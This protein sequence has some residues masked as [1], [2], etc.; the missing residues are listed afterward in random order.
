M[1]TSSSSAS[2]GLLHAVYEFSF[3]VLALFH[4]FRGASP[5]E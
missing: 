3:Q 2:G 5:A 4:Q 1:G